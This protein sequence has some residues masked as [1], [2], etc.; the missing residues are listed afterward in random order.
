VAAQRGAAQRGA[1]QRGAAQRG[2]A[3]RGAARSRFAPLPSHVYA[4]YY[5]TYL[6]PPAVSI[7]AIARLS[8]ARYF[9]LAFLESTGRHSCTLG[10]NGDLARPPSYYARDIA[11]L[12]AAGGDVIPSFGGFAADQGGTEIADSCPDVTRIAAAYESVIA[13]LHVTRLDM[14]V[15]ARSLGNAAGISRRNRA[16]AL[17]LT[18]AAR[19]GI[20]L[21]IQYTLPVE[22]GGLPAGARAVL[23]SAVAHDAAVT[24]VNMMVFDYFAPGKANMGRAAVQAARSTHAQLAALYRGRGSARIWAMEAMTMLP[25]IDDY[26]PGTEVTYLTDARTVLRFA[27]ARGMNLLSIWAV[28]RDNGGCRGTPDADTCS[29]IIQPEWAFSHLLVPFT[30]VR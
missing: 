20:P 22:R 25:G 16:I 12:R 18:W 30:A 10:W 26:P 24:S 8:G 1:A 6:R 7:P 2:A 15:E 21:Q 13:A 23:R 19:R 27:H 28:Q 17:T 11:A 29:G 3:Q 5:E 4:P 14:D 9:T